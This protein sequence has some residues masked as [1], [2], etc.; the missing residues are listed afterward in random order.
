MWLKKSVDVD[1]R[2]E[3]LHKYVEEIYNIKCAVK[4]V[5]TFTCKMFK[6]TEIT[7]INWA[8]FQEIFELSNHSNS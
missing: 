3:G 5:N 8:P 6:C 7:V 2:T 1:L 4:L